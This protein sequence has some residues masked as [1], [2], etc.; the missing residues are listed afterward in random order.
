MLELKTNVK[1]T[2]M[3]RARQLYCH[4]RQAIFNL[5]TKGTMSFFFFFLHIL[6]FSSTIWAPGAAEPLIYMTGIGKSGSE[7]QTAAGSRPLFR[8]PFVVFLQ[9]RICWHLWERCLLS[10]LHE[11]LHR[12]CNWAL[13]RG[14]VW[15]NEYKQKDP[16]GN[17]SLWGRL[18]RIIKSLCLYLYCFLFTE[19]VIRVC[20]CPGIVSLMRSNPSFSTPT[21]YD[22]RWWNDTG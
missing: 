4:L 15:Q 6:C 8:R 5:P 13:W 9:K 11:F 12:G 17:V 20:K 7:M 10:F 18:M 21:N 19:H 2:W 1:K 16:K 3:W 22:C 14:D